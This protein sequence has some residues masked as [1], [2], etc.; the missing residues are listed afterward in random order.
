MGIDAVTFN[1]ISSALKAIPQEM[2]INLLRSA[3]SSIVR[4]A[5]DMS[6]AIL[7]RNGNVVVQAEHIPMLLSAIP[8]FFEGCA[9]YHPIHEIAPDEF[10]ISNDSYNGG[11]HL[12]DIAIFT[13]I[14]YEGEIIG[15]SASVA[16]HVDLGGIT[17]GILG[18]YATEIFQ[19][20]LIIPPIKA[21]LENGKIG[22]ALEAIIRANIRVPHETIG[23]LNA[24]IVGNRTGADRLIGLID[25]YGL[26]TIESCMAELLNYSER[27]TRQQIEKVPDGMYCGEA[28][29]DDDGRSTDGSSIRIHVKIIVN[30]SNIIADFS[31][32]DPQNDGIQN[33]TIGSTIGAVHSTIRHIFLSASDVPPNA[34]CN[35]PIKVIA[36]KGSIANP[37]R[38]A[39]V[40]AR[41]TISYRIYEAIMQAFSNVLPE[42]VIAPGYNSSCC[43]ALSLKSQQD[44][45]IISEVIAGGWGASFRND[46]ADGLPFPLS[47]CANV[48]AEY[49]DVEYDFLRL[50]RYEL[51]PDSCGHGKFRGGLGELREY[52]ILKS[53]VEFTAFTDRFKLQPEGIFGGTGGKSGRITV[54]KKNGDIMNLPSKTNYILDA[55]DILTIEI[56]GGGGYGD[57]TERERELIFK[58]LREGKISVEVAKNIYH[59]DQKDIIG[60][61]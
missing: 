30:G 20:G 56:G 2:G 35:R 3:Y 11:Q 26:E 45:K 17:P 21:K 24:Q 39:C 46:G 16:H 52:E 44:Y 43:T 13:P 50:L 37:H 28:F 31:E 42:R 25:K 49:V 8:S 27:L 5:K 54:V 1:I 47:N 14:Y 19:E 61:S 38:P 48:P 36:P 15:F 53:G 9:K 29:L 51:V 6:A 12:S 22:G 10:L 60:G 33:S 23:D 32:S 41:V 34:G 4:E 55:G 7:D 40:H 59:I 57:P 18:P 58:D